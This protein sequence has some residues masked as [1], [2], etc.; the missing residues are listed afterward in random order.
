M[1]RILELFGQDTQA[2]DVD[3][4]V[5][6]TQQI[7][8]FSQRKCFKVRKSQPEVS[9]GTCSVLQGKSDAPVVICPNRFLAEGQIFV[10]C[11]HL[12]TNHEPG[13]ELHVVPEISVPGGSIDYV[14]ASVRKGSVKD[15]VAI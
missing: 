14:L 3:W 8:P 9:I 13:N 6:L 15:F 7:C 10:D 1:N 5:A 2:T 12:L 4:A 11:L